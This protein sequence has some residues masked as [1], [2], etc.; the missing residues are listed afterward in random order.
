MY[1]AD[2][3]NQFKDL[4]TQRPED[5]PTNLIVDNTNPQ[6]NLFRSNSFSYGKG[7][8]R[9]NLTHSRDRGALR[10]SNS[11]VGKGRD[12]LKSS[13]G[14]KSKKSSSSGIPHLRPEGPSELPGLSTTANKWIAQRYAPTDAESQVIR[15]SQLIL[16]KMSEENFESLS[17][18]LLDV[19]IENANILEEILKKIFE[20]ALTETKFRSMY[21]SLCLKLSVKCPSFGPEMTFK[22]LL[23]NMCQTVFEASLSE[24]KAE[25]DKEKQSDRELTKDEKEIQA[26]ME[27]MAKKRIVGN[28]HFIGELYKRQMLNDKIMHRCIQELMGDAS[29]PAPEDVESLCAMLTNIGPQLD[30]GPHKQKIEVSFMYLIDVSK[31]KK[32]PSRILF[33]IQDL[34]QLRKNNWVSRSEAKNQQQAKLSTSNGNVPT[35][36]QRENNRSGKKDEPKGRSAIT[37]SSSGINTG[38]LRNSNSGNSN[39]GNSSLRS[40][41]TQV[42]GKGVLTK[43]SSGRNEEK[44][45]SVLNK[46]G[47]SSSLKAS[48]MDGIVQE[49]LHKRGDPFL[50]ISKVEAKQHPEVAAKLITVALDKE[51]NQHSYCKQ[52]IE[53]FHTLFKESVFTQESLRRGFDIAIERTEKTPQDSYKWI[54]EDLGL[55]ISGGILDSYLSLDYLQ[56]SLSSLS[57][58]KDMPAL[59]IAAG[60]FKYLVKGIGETEVKQMMEKDK[61]KLSALFPKDDDSK[62]NSFFD[63]F[64]GFFEK[65]QSETSIAKELS[66]M[67]EKGQRNS[68]L[69]FIEESMD[70]EMLSDPQ[71]SRSACSAFFKMFHKNSNGST[72]KENEI[73]GN[74][75]TAL[76]YFLQTPALQSACVQE[77]EQLCSSLHFPEGMMERILDSCYEAGLLGRKGILEWKLNSPQTPDKKIALEQLSDFLSTLE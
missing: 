35:I 5:L 77:I 27:I 44:G 73:I 56:S 30:Q 67:I 39:S 63:Q 62:I 26:T 59:D 22:R 60:V 20:K 55:L 16:N 72:S 50:P 37:N 23:L 9:N 70:E 38:F 32:V 2:F 33:M 24:A 61:F 57:Q 46:S 29:E 71:I 51:T 14:G 54:I 75:G 3:L 76:K 36:L 12:R 34:L 66:S 19:G 21:A 52:L 6:G 45:R 31:N 53:L 49:F 28:I 13:T 10:S 64:Q 4:C 1:T 7:G 69:N 42:S 74:L 65:N 8:G 11:S 47:S 25:K 40:S 43:S 48:W 58:S 17:E 15:N 18:K 68:I 41:Q